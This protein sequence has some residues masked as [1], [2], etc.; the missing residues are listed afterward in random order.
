MK[1]NKK[2]LLNAVKICSTV[3]NDSSHLPIWDSMLFQCLYGDVTITSRDQRNIL[4]HRFKAE[5]ESTIEPFLFN[6]STMTKI[7]KECSDDLINITNVDHRLTISFDVSSFDFKVDILTAMDYI[8]S[9]P[10]YG[11]EKA[12]MAIPVYFIKDHPK[13]WS[14]FA[15]TDELR[16]VMQFISIE[17]VEDEMNL[18]ATNAHLLF[19]FK[20]EWHGE[21]QSYLLPSKLVGKLCKL[22]PKEDIH[23]RQFEKWSE[24]RIG[25]TSLLFYYPDGRYPNWKAVIEEKPNKVT[26]D[27][28]ELK[29]AIRQIH[30]VSNT[31]THQ[32]ILDADDH[33]T[34]LQCH[35]LDDG[36]DAKVKLRKA[37]KEGEEVTIGFNSV[38]LLQCLDALT[39]SEITMAYSTP[40]RSVIFRGN[41]NKDTL[42][43]LMPVMVN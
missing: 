23:L 14:N 24:M 7:L 17:A 41:G 26:F 27:A 2:E 42:A 36:N 19:N 29:S 38:L 10:L 15:S 16:Q 28:K 25:T 32:I 33:R 20:S 3:K 9:L 1:I 18:V 30:S 37:V 21:P 11:E 35:D 8:N 5:D 4:S 40:N 39:G 6:G 12:A 31:S 22:M 13:A 34:I 43:L